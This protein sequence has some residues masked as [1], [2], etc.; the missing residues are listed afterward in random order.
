M[1]VFRKQGVY[2]I[3]YYVDGRRKRERISPDKKQAET[4]LRKRKVAIAEGKYLDK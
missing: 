4:V 1:G 3:D 2:R